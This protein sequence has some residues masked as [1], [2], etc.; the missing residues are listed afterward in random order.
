MYGLSCPISIAKG[1]T[2]RPELMGYDRDSGA[3]VGNTTERNFGK[4][5]IVGVQFQLTF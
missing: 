4:E 3:T 5:Y 1:F 2:I